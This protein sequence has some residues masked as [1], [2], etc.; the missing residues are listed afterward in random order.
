MLLKKHEKE[1]LM[2][3]HCM[4]LDEYASL[5]QEV[6]IERLQGM[7][8][9]D[10]THTEIETFELKTRCYTYDHTRLLLLG[11]D[12]AD[13]LGHSYLMEVVQVVYDVAI[14]LTNKEYQERFDEAI[15]V[16]ARVEQPMIPLLSMSGASEEEQLRVVPDR[17][18]DLH[19]VH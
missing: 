4:S 12:H 3:E 6:V 5:E 18:S 17:A 9:Y 19:L 15:D 10:S 1:G 2:Q 16:Q 13:I 7:N 8:E 14:F 11:H